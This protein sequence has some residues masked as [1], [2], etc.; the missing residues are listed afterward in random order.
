METSATTPSDNPEVE[1]E[2]S[3]DSND[4]GD[5]IPHDSEVWPPDSG[6]HDQERSLAN[7]HTYVRS[8]EP[9]DYS[10]FSNLPDL[11][12][13]R[14][15]L[16]DVDDP[17][18]LSPADFT[19]YFPFVDNVWR[20]CR[21]VEGQN[22]MTEWYWCRLKRATNYQR[23]PPRPTPEGKKARKKRTRDDTMCGM[24][25]K[26]IHHR[27]AIPKCTVVRDVPKD[28]RHTHDLDHIDSLKRNSGIME[29]ARREAIRGF[30]PTSIYHKLWDE[31][32]K[33]FDAGGKYMKQSDVRNVQYHW[34]QLNPQVILKVHDG[35]RQKRTGPR[36]KPQPSQTHLKVDADPQHAYHPSADRQP[37]S[38]T[39]GMPLLSSRET[40]RVAPN[41]I[42]PD[43][44]HYRDQN[45]VFL[46]PYLPTSSSTAHRSTP[47]VTLTYAS[48]LD[49]RISLL[50]GQQTAISGS[51]TKAM[52]HYLR[53]RHDAILIGVRTAISDDPGLNC[54]LA[55]AGGYGGPAGLHQPR[56][57]IIDPRGRLLIRPDMKIL[58]MAADGKG[59]AP[60]VVIGPGTEVHPMAVKILKNH[61]GE[62][63]KIEEYNHPSPG[64]NWEGIFT[65]LSREGI[66]SVMVEGGGIVLSELLN[67]RYA[68]LIDSI[69]ITIAPTFLG[70]A[71]VTVSPDPN[72]VQPG[73]AL[74]T[75]LSNV[76]WQPMG[77]DDVVLCGKLKPDPVQP[78]YSILQGI[79]EFSRG[80]EDHHER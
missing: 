40:G 24:A 18:E 61:G 71:G 49:S 1:A 34:R 64:L 19:A 58:K 2:V 62:F 39:T 37:G 43:A 79:E 10:L 78:Q 11:A 3:D 29:I 44:L 4:T 47:H 22:E 67:A 59:K 27:G 72:F 23:P 46:E 9:T 16:F 76:V 26:V 53:S 68:S 14:Q 51:E 36:P 75:R 80:A 65:I 50:P 7:G 20:K 60:W 54:R 15:R 31:P 32:E 55:G 77:K 5:D 70:K 69:I 38:S 21:S 74:P 56:P 33:M 30:V 8:T 17:I 42:P 63:L 35:F 6:D 73:Q 28:A 52:T 57:I 12:A 25:L 45:R 41:M 48:S 66:K 13:M